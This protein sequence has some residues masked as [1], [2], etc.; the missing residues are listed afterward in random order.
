MSYKVE[1]PDTI[2]GEIDVWGL[3]N[4]LKQEV[5][6]RLEQ[7]L[8][9]GHEVTCFRLPAPS[10]TFVYQLNLADDRLNGVVHWMIFHLTYGHEDQTIYVSQCFHAT[11]ENWQAG[12]V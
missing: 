2:R 6:R 4:Q 12:D 1:V 8:E 5:Y 11:E 9:Y 7:D 3:S 10:P